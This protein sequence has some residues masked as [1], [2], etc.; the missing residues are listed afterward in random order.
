[1]TRGRTRSFTNRALSDSPRPRTPN[2]S[3]PIT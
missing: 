1:M 3:H 2:D